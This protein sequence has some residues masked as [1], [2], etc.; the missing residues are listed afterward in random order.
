MMIRFD[1][2]N[3]GSFLEQSSLEATMARGLEELQSLLSRS[4]PDT[5]AR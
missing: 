2:G 5:R 1:T 3:T 4:G